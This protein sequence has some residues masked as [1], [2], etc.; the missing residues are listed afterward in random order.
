MNDMTTSNDQVATVTSIN[1][2]AGADNARQMISY[3]EHMTDVGD[4]SAHIMGVLQSTLELEKLIELFDDEL[5]S[6]VPHDHLAYTNSEEEVS[7]IVGKAARNTCSYRLVLF[8]KELGEL[9]VSR[10]TKLLEDEIVKMEN[11]ISALI[12]PLRNALL[13][14]Q[15]VEKAYLDPLTGVNNRAAFD[16]TIEQEFDLARRHSNNLSLM[17]LDIDHFKQI[18]DSFGH[19]VGD[20]VLKSFADCITDCMRRSDSIFRYGGEEFAVLLRSTQ[21]DGA[22]LLAERMRERIENLDFDYESVSV[23][24]TVSIGVAQLNSDEECTNLIDRAD[25]YLYEAK[26]NGRNR[27]VAKQS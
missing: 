3:P 15:A 4:I 16:K 7:F 25:K 26:Q 12:Y 11:L 5:A 20:A 17:M 21:L 9:T 6:I 2:A 13:Y 27:V 18:N 23:S 1:K 24:V 14:K 8:G 19:V 22:A 10:N